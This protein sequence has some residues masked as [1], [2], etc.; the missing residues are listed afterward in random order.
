PEAAIN[1]IQRIEAIT[2]VR[3]DIISTGPDRVETMIDRNPFAE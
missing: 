1:Y 2:G 3:I